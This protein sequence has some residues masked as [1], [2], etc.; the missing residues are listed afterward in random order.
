MRRVR[1]TRHRVRRPR[2]WWLTTA[3]PIALALLPPIVLARAAMRDAVDVPWM[4][5]WTFARELVRT[6]DGTF[7]PSNLWEQHNEHRVPVTKLVLHALAALSGWDVRWEI[8]ATVVVGIGSLVLLVWMLVRTAPRGAVGVLVLLASALQCSLVQWQNW[9]WGWQLGLVLAEAAAIAV[10]AALVRVPTAPARWGIVATALAVAGALS[11]GAGLTLL[12]VVPAG[13]VLAR[14]AG[15]PV[16]PRTI[17]VAVVVSAATVAAYA[18]GWARMPGQPAPVPIAGNLPQIAEYAFT[19]LGA[20]IASRDKTLAFRWGA[21]ASALVALSALVVWIVAPRRRQATVPWLALAAF[22]IGVGLLTAGGRAGTGMH[23]ALL[24]RYT[25]FSIPLWIALG[26][27]VAL[28]LASIPW[29]LGRALVLAALL[30]GLGLAIWHGGQSWIYGDYRMLG[31][32]AAARSARTCIAD[33]A[34]APDACWRTL[35]WSV[36]YGRERALEL[37]RHR[38]G[39]WRP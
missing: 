27:L 15:A 16:R 1:Y 19:V 25:T 2:H 36:P 11:N 28:A 20:P 34:T 22:S 14:W 32:A 23:T 8:A 12:A 18:S 38:L 10:A 6:H 21:T 31:R 4:D 3:L 7:R 24:S 33:P 9:T 35:C 13:L 37:Q 17:A 26:P 30:P 5:Q 29:R 39:P